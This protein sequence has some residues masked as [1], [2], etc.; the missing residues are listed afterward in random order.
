MLYAYAR[1]NF[2]SPRL[3]QT[4]QRNFLG[5]AG[6]QISGGCHDCPRC[7]GKKAEVLV[8]MTFIAA[9]TCLVTWKRKSTKR[10][11]FF[12]MNPIQVP[13]DGGKQV[14]ILGIPSGQCKRNFLGSF[15]SAA[16]QLHF[17]DSDRKST[18][19]NS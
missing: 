12:F 16:E 7:Y 6:R 18:R 8:S 19:L 2:A 15:K 4:H 13:N 11:L 10:P 5:M 1:K 17:K 14:N 9:F 3:R